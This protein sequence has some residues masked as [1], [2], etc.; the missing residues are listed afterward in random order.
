MG[1]DRGDET[2][3]LW[4]EKTGVV[5]WEMEGR[6]CRLMDGMVLSQVTEKLAE[7]KVEVGSFLMSTAKIRFKFKDGTVTNTIGGN[8]PPVGG[9]IR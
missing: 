3:G 1:R 7:V 2:T 8:Y 9:S 4:N 6:M 5:E